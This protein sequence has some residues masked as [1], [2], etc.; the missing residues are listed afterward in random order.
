MTLIKTLI[1][2]GSL[3]TSTMMLVQLVRRATTL[4]CGALITQIV[5]Y[6]EVSTSGKKEILREKAP[7]NSYFLNVSNAHLQ[8]AE[9]E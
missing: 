5:Q 7:I 3:V 9:Q 1:D 4:P 6:A 8:E 2:Y